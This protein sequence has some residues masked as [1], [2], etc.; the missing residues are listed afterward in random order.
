MFGCT[1]REH[2]QAVQAAIQKQD[3]QVLERILAKK[4][5][6]FSD[7]SFSEDKEYTKTLFKDARSGALEIWMVLYRLNQA[8]RQET[9]LTPDSIA[10]I[11]ASGETSADIIR[12]TLDN[13]QPADSSIFEDFI[14]LAK[15]A[16]ILS[17]VLEWEKKFDGAK[18]IID[19]SL[20]AA[21]KK[22]EADKVRYL[23]E[24]EANP[25][26]AGALA[27]QVA[28]ESRHKEII[29]Q[30][31]PLTRLDLHGENILAALKQKDTPP[32]LLDLLEKEVQRATLEKAENDNYT[33]VDLHTLAE[34]QRLPG[35][36]TLTTLFNF[37]ARQ[38]IFIVGK[39]KEHEVT[40]ISTRDFDEISAR[41]MLEARWQ[42]LIDMNGKADHPLR[43][44]KPKPPSP[45]QKGEM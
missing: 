21:A 41:D 11:A 17:F 27:L 19:K 5:F 13:T 44:H 6:E 35:G 15:T 2:H 43:L 4:G 36:I 8:N 31:M 34:T 29:N 40:A 42:K 33:L 14:A 45:G 9:K 28:I 12:F 3:A 20:A 24:K 18:D 10:R 25:N 38:Q 23:L 16:S 1:R 7:K 22:G 37:E 30:L 32:D 26:W 39:N